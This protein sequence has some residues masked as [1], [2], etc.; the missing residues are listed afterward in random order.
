MNLIDDAWRIARRAWSVRLAL[1]AALFSGLELSVPFF[2][3]F[4]PQRAMAGLA[5]VAGI[6]SAIARLIPQP[7]MRRG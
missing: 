6:G 5:L 4:L 1:L 2:G 3:D 7:R